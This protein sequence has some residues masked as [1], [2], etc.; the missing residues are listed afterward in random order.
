MPRVL[1]LTKEGCKPCL[2][3][4]RILEELRSATPGLEFEELDMASERGTELAVH[5]NVLYPPAV[6]I[7]GRLF[8]YGKIHEAPLRD[9]VQAVESAR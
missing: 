5:H 4:K 1:L 6:F 2:R 7:D 3:V 8:A 9:A